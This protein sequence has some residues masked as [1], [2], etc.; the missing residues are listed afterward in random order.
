[1]KRQWKGCTKCC[2]CDVSESIQHLFFDFPMTK[3]MWGIVCLTFGI[4]KPTDVRHLF[5]LWL[6][7]FSKKQRNLVFIRVAAFCWAIWI[8]RND[9]VFHKSHS[10][11]ILQV[12]FRGTH[13]IRS[14][15]ILSKEDGRI[16]LKE[17]CRRVEIVMMEIFHKSGWN[18]LR[19]I[20]I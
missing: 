9:I 17:A 14:W 5:G 16:I 4:S 3:L 1:M 18:A 20:G 8:S 2:L 10:I 13:W 7:N 15:A 11:S 19:R 6:R 12:M